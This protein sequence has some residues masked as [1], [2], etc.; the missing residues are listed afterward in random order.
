MS[1]KQKRDLMLEAELADEVLNIPEDE[2]WTYR[3][4][5]LQAPRIVD[6]SVK[7][8]VKVLIIVF[9]IFAI[10]L[11]IF[12]SIRAVSNDEFK[13]AQV[14]SGYEFIKYSN[15]GQVSEVSVDFVDG[16]TSKPYTE[17]HEYAFNCDEKLVTINIGKDVEKIDGKSF[18]SC[19]NLENIFVD[20]D[21]RYYCD[22]NGVLYDKALTTVI[23]YPSA[24]DIYLMREAGYGFTLPEDGSIT[25]DDFH[26][27]VSIIADTLAKGEDAAALKED[28]TVQ[29]FVKLTGVEDFAK[30]AE[31]YKNTAGIY[32]IPSTVTEIGKLAFA[33]SPVTEIYIPVGV[34][35]IGTLGFFKAEKLKEIYSYTS[36][37]TVSDTVLAKAGKLNAVRSLPDGLEFIGSDAFTYDRNITYMYV[38]ASVKEIGHH[39]FF[40]MAFKS[41]DYI[42]GTAKINVE[43]D[44]KAFKANTKTGESWL[45]KIEN[46]AFKKNVDVVYSAVREK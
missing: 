21:N 22:V 11:S 12:F 20:D 27:A 41:G 25:N 43:L 36:E 9:L 42:E 15:P 35:S 19:K 24:H 28:S 29:K 5:G 2:I 10:S 44:E 4:E 6:R 40:N 13:Y 31:D 30:Y 16:D 14:D 3:I 8:R 37:K 45:P 26:K 39:A 17:I 38:P 33:Y 23:C 46:G 1:K 32:V 18:Y 34:K 7:P